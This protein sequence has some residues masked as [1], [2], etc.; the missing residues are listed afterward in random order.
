MGSGCPAAVRSERMCVRR[1]GDFKNI[2]KNARSRSTRAG[3]GLSGCSVRGGGA[4]CCGDRAGG[5]DD[6]S[7]L[8]GGGVVE[9]GLRVLG[10]GCAVLGD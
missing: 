5:G 2:Q 6:L 7:G 9:E 8:R 4:V 3:E 1:D 10:E